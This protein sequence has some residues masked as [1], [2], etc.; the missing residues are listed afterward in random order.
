MNKTLLTNKSVVTNTPSSI[1]VTAGVPMNKS[2]TLIQ[3]VFNLI[4][5]GRLSLYSFIQGVV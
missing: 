3:T 5:T 2:L 4:H 1:V